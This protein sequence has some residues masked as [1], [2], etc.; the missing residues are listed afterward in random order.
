MPSADNWSTSR[1][2]PQ[3]ACDF[4]K[5]NGSGNLEW[6]EQSAVRVG[7]C[8]P[9]VC[10][11][12]RHRACSSHAVVADAPL[13]RTRNVAIGEVLVAKIC[14]WS[15]RETSAFV[16]R[17]KGAERGCANYAARYEDHTQV[18]PPYQ[19]CAQ[20]SRGAM[21]KVIVC[22]RAAEFVRWAEMG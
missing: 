16:E 1:L 11:I 22:F 19:R 21:C 20:W 5:V 2:T 8:V 18:S 17:K 9:Y 7:G 6:A 4:A 14:Q 10:L 12:S 3:P 15:R 13:Q